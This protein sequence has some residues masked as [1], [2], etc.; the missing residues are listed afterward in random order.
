M[1]IERAERVELPELDVAEAGLFLEARG[2]ADQCFVLWTNAG[3][4]SSHSFRNVPHIIY[5]SGGKYLK[6]GSYVDAGNVANNQLLNT[7][8]SAAIQDTG[9][10]MEEFGEGEPGQLAVVRA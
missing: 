10:T 2:L 5:G 7:L 8:I 4:D 3:A 6:Q 1:A 9:T